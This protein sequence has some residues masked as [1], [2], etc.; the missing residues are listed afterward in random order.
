MDDI[1]IIWLKVLEDLKQTFDEDTFNS[2]FKNTKFLKF[3]NNHVYILVEH[4]FEALTYEAVFR[5]Y[6]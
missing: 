6:F 5:Q 3:N 4:E 1:N 2:V